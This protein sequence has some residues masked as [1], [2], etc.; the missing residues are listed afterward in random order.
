[1]G[2]VKGREVTSVL[3]APLQ[4]PVKYSIM[5]YEVSLRRSEGALIEVVSPEEWNA[6]THD[7]GH[8]ET[9]KSTIRKTKAV[10][11]KTA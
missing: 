5:D 9:P 8:Y 3:N 10:S 4:D 7:K 1:M 11:E 6:E 2:F